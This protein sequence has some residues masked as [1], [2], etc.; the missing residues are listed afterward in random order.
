MRLASGS[1]SAGRF[2]AVPFDLLDTR[3]ERVTTYIPWE[4]A[5]GTGLLEPEIDHP[6]GIHGILEDR[7][8]MMTRQQESVSARMPKT[9]EAH[10]LQ[11][12]SGV[13]VIDVL[14]TSIDQDGNPYELTRFV[15]R[16]DRT[17]LFY[18]MAVE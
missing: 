17:G 2:A 1:R 14:H 18:D 8:H 13:P 10:H 16:A 7:G 15:M 9:E 6:Y 11:L 3:Q 12:P 5:Q 4:I